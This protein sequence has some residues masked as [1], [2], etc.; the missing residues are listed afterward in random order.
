MLCVTCAEEALLLGNL[1][2][3]GGVAVVTEVRFSFPVMVTV[4]S[5]K[6]P[7][8]CV[9]VLELMLGILGVSY[10]LLFIKFVIIFRLLL[11]TGLKDV[12]S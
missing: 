10:K 11:L 6:T 8:A 3:E 4:Q 5:Y 1:R 2:Q 12:S 9:C 7:I